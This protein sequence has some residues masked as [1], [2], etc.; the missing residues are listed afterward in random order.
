[1]WFIPLV[2]NVCDDV[3]C[4]PGKQCVLDADNRPDCVCGRRFCYL[5]YAPVCGSDGNT[6]TS[7]SFVWQRVIPTGT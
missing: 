5:L 7:V 2:S 4:P 3:T 6:Q 1:M